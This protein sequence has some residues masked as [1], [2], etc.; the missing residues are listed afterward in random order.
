MA[1]QSAPS[2]LL[3][4][5]FLVLPGVSTLAARELQFSAEFSE[6]HPAGGPRSPDERGF[7]VINVGVWEIRTT[8]TGKRKLPQP[9]LDLDRSPGA[10]N[11][12]CFIL[13]RKEA[14]KPAERVH[15]TIRPDPAP[16][17]VVLILPELP[18]VDRYDYTLTIPPGCLAV[19]KEWKPANAFE[20]VP[21]PIDGDRF[22]KIIER[23]NPLPKPDVKLL[24]G[25]KTGAVSLRAFYRKFFDPG[26]EQPVD[27]PPR[28]FNWDRDSLIQARLEVDASFR[29]E[30]TGEYLNKV[31]AELGGYL[32]G[33]WHLSLVE[34]G[35]SS[36][37]QADQQFKTV[38][39][40]ASVAGW[41]WWNTPWFNRIGHIFLPKDADVPVSPPLFILGYDFVAHLRRDDTTGNRDYHGNHR[42]S[43]RFF[44]TIPIAQDI[45]VP[46]LGKADFD[47]AIDVAGVW[48][49]ESGKVAPEAKLA[50]E[51]TFAQVKTQPTFTFNYV[52]GRSAPT[53][54]HFDALLGGLKYEF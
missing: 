41:L 40:T 8:P 21:L 26:G 4:L 15:V 13:Q 2:V 44:W 50:L 14:G 51:F 36:K 38:D 6:Q 42:I 12:D 24:Q 48:D 17:G 39:Q 3:R 1:M 53:F 46:I 5:L 37:L 28:A 31:E 27:A 18:D 29:P 34:I 16:R 20:G 35:F 47:L 33:E 30:E 23:A 10:R 7:N 9:G 49:V 19:K 32:A 52:N 25:E 45:P 43:G 22:R 54:E 11:A